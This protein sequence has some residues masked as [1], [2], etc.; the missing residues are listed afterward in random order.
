VPHAIYASYSFKIIIALTA[1][2]LIAVV[3]LYTVLPECTHVAVGAI[4]LT[5]HCSF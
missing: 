5:E 3:F 4:P 2:P 1:R